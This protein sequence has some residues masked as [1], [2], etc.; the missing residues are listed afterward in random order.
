[1]HAGT[2]INHSHSDIFDFSHGTVTLRTCCGDESWGSYTRLP[3]GQWIWHV[4]IYQTAPPVMDFIVRPG[5][6]S[7]SITDAADPSKHY[8][9]RRRVFKQC[10]L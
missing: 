5:P 7:M 4:Q 10:P 8:V 1:V 9:L 6:F 3:D 2:I